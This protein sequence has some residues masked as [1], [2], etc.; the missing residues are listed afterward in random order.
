MCGSA[1]VG[2]PVEKFATDAR[3]QISGHWYVRVGQIAPFALS[4][5]HKIAG[6]VE[7]QGTDA[8][9][10]PVNELTMVRKDG[11]ETM[12][13]FPLARDEL[14]RDGSALRR[15]AVGLLRFHV[16]HGALHVHQELRSRQARF[17]VRLDDH[18]AMS[19]ARGTSTS[20][21]FTLLSL[22]SATSSAW[23]RDRTSGSNVGKSA[24]GAQAAT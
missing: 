13:S 24:A 3:Q 22:A 1:D 9:G 14:R 2:H 15:L 7:S 12:S 4:S 8:F 11:S 18:H 19:D 23:I 20:A 10:V 17:R 5:A 21:I 6:A 16:E